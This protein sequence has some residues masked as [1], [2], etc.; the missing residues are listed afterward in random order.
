MGTPY[1]WSADT[2]VA[3]A[4]LIRRFH[5]ASRSFIL[6]PGIVWQSA[7]AYPSGGDV[8]CHNDLA[9]WN[10]VFVDGQPGAF[11]DW[12]AAA[13]GPPLWG[14]VRARLRKNVWR[15]LAGLR[16]QVQKVVRRHPAEAAA[17]IASA[18]MCQRRPSSYTKPTLAAILGP[19]LG[20]ITVRARA[21]GRCIA[22][23]WQFSLDGGHTWNPLPVTTMAHTFLRDASAGLTYRFRFRS[24]R[25]SAVSAWSPYAGVFMP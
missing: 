3:V 17:I 22:Y 18:N 12:D 10:T 6:P 11:I 16:N 9:P 20:Q 8:I 15:S 24:T 14:P 2:L 21:R 19:E 13:P 23:E 1:L 5:D 25:G 7:V 4:R